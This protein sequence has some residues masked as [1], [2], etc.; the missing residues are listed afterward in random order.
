LKEGARENC[1][2]HILDITE[3]RD[4][5]VN[6]DIYICAVDRAAGLA[7]KYVAKLEASEIS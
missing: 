3:F 1:F 5:V 2:F 7:A 4:H 6:E